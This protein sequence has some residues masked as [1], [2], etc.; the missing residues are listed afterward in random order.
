MFRWYIVSVPN[1]GESRSSGFLLIKQIG[2][3]F[4]DIN[5]CINNAEI[6]RNSLFLN[7]VPE[8]HREVIIVEKYDEL[9]AAKEG[10]ERGCKNKPN[11]RRSLSF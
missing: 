2:P 8:N 1:E 7:Y 6:E 9:D 10:G 3:G 4:T 5:V 11:I